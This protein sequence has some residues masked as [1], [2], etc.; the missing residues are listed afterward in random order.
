[1]RYAPLPAIGTVTAAK[2][3]QLRI[4]ENLAL[5]PEIAGRPS[6]LATGF[7]PIRQIH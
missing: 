4:L 3:M 7:V 1:M 6:C 5:I 2:A